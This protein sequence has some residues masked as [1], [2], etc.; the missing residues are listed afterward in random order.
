M[1]SDVKESERSLLKLEV[2]DLL[3]L[4]FGI[5]VCIELGHRI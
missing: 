1:L 3:H 5:N 4:R 2:N